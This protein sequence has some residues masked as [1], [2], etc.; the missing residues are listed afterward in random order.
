MKTRDCCDPEIAL[1]PSADLH[2]EMH[3]KMLQRKLVISIWSLKIL[4]Q[5]D[6]MKMK[7]DI[8]FIPIKHDKKKKGDEVVVKVLQV[9]N[10]VVEGDHTKEL[11]YFMKHQMQKAEERELEVLKK[12]FSEETVPK[13]RPVHPHVTDPV[14]Q[15]PYMPTRPHWNSAFQPIFQCSTNHSRPYSGLSPS[16]SNSFNISKP[17]SNKRAIIYHSL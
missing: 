15:Q 7:K 12:I 9:L 16:S 17:T 6:Q 11:L 4:Q 5:R 14:Y 8:L 10:K 2:W 1:D 3:Q 13:R